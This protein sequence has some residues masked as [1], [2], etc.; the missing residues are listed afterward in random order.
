MIDVETKADKEVYNAAKADVLS[1]LEAEISALYVKH[2]RKGGFKLDVDQ[3]A[4]VEG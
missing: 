1:R 2:G 4:S 3:L